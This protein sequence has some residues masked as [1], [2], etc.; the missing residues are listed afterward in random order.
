MP[1][2]L[3]CIHSQAAA[4]PPSHA[5]KQWSAHGT[6]LIS[7]GHLRSRDARPVDGGMQVLQGHPQRRDAAVAAHR[8]SAAEHVKQCRQARRVPREGPRGTFY[9]TLHNMLSQRG[10][11]IDS[12]TCARGV[13]SS[14]YRCI[15]ADSKSLWHLHWLLQDRCCWP[16][17]NWRGWLSGAGDAERDRQAA[18]SG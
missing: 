11:L 18:Q 7:E 10:N 9:P 1:H 8:R 15:D 4:E 5:T 2:W 17:C 12:L 3:A 6:V 14:P 16:P 13:S